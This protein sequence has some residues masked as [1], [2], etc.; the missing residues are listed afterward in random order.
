[1]VLILNSYIMSSLPPA[2]DGVLGI[3]RNRGSASM[4]PNLHDKPIRNMLDVRKRILEYSS[5]QDEIKSAE[6]LKSVVNPFRITEI[7]I[8]KLV[9]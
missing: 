5:L 6:Q 3:N 2:V 1:M 7:E 8:R 9:A 4:A